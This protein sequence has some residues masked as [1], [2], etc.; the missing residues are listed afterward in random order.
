MMDELGSLLKTGDKGPVIPDRKVSA[1]KKPA[2]LKSLQAAVQ[3]FESIFTQ[4]LMKSMRETVHKGKL[5]NGGRGEEIFTG[6]LDQKTAVGASKKGQGLGLA[7][8]LVERYARN[9]HGAGDDAK[10]TKIDLKPVKS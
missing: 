8:M 9:I 1:E 6:M 4:M 10:G 7:K 3:D 5:F 2:D